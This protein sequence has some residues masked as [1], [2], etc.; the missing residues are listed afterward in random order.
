[1]NG[2]SV[3]RTGNLFSI[4]SAEYEATFPDGSTQTFWSPPWNDWT[5][6]EEDS[7][8]MDY[9]IRLWSERNVTPSR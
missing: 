3:R 5:D 4:A 8:A 7:N 2:I 1:M 6:D 9:A